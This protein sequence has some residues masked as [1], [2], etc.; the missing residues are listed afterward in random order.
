MKDLGINCIVIDAADV[1]ATQY[2]EVMKTDNIDAVKLVKALR[3]EDLRTV[4]IREKENLDD[5]SVVRIR[6]IIQ[7]IY[8]FINLVLN[9]CYIVMELKY[10]INLILQEHIGQT[11]LLNG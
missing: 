10:L 5:R 11:P 7:K 9:I 1:P 4:Y 3:K 6:K 8:V 2:E